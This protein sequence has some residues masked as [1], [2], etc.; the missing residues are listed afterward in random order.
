M[1]AYLIV[2]DGEVLFSHR[3]IL[4]VRA[5][6]RAYPEPCEVHVR[7]EDLDTKMDTKPA[8]RGDLRDMVRR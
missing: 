1:H 6:L 2:C 7:F 8:F 3:N 5:F 4:A